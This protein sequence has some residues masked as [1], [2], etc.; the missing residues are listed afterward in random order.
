[1][2][3]EGNK[4][5][6]L[7]LN[8]TK[9]KKYDIIKGERGDRVGTMVKCRYC[10]RSFDRT[11]EKENEY[12]IQPSPK[13]YY[14]IECYNKHLEDKKRMKENQV[15]IPE[16]AERKT[17]KKAIVHCRICKQPFD[18]LALQEDVDWTQPKKGQYYHKKCYDDWAVKREDISVN[19]KLDDEIWEK[20]IWDFLTREKKM[21]P[22]TGKYFNQLKILKKKRTV[23]GIYFALRY[24]F[25]KC[26]GR[27]EKMNG[28]IGIVDLIYDDS[29]RYWSEKVQKQE[30]VLEKIENQIRSMN[31]EEKPSGRRVAKKKKEKGG[32]DLKKIGEM[33]FD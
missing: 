11:I 31:Q 4:I 27:I 18:R 9:K 16:P 5:S 1:M 24:Y 20:A 13:W 15:K 23:K 17:P 10:K 22:D 7:F 2:K 14:H 29:A 26:G 19:S 28:G 25:D 8:L 33:N 30:D 32:I 6:S 21:I 12:W 3:R